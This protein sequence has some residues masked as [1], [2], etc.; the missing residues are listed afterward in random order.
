MS[1][2][3]IL[4]HGKFKSVAKIAIA[5]KHNSRD[6]AVPNADPTGK[7]ELLI[8]SD[9]PDIL[10][11]E[12]LAKYEIKPASNAVLAFEMLLTYSPEMKGKVPL[13][14]WKK[15]NIEWLE[16]KYGKERILSAHLHLDE[17]TPHIQAIIMPL[18]K[19]SFRGGPERVTLCCRDFLGGAKKLSRNQDEYRDAMAEF[20]L[21]RGIKGSK[22]VH[23]ELKTWYG[24]FVYMIERATQA[25]KIDAAKLFGKKPSL[26]G[27][28]KWFDETK[29][30]AEMAF[31]KAYMFN[32]TLEKMGIENDR[33]TKKISHMQHEIKHSQAN[34]LEQQL[35]IANTEIDTLIESG[36][37]TAQELD[38]AKELAKQQA[39]YI[40]RQAYEIKQLKQDLADTYG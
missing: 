32:A 5:G 26:L 28:K 12:R 9:R 14:A 2:F 7:I 24:G 39:D 18:V 40:D 4:R 34:Y 16:K 13:D 22:A 6:M 1:R 15:K 38:Q 33:L 37:A 35:G 31:S 3:A 11:K 29:K 20:G 27:L 21:E 25:A 10:F 17:S 36:T 23:V 8:G 19:K 30:A